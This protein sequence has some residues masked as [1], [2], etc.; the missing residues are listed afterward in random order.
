MAEVQFH[1]FTFEN[2]VKQEFF[3]GHV[4][5]YSS[6]WDVPA[7]L[8]RSDILQS[9]FRGL[10]V[11]IKT[12]R[13]GSPLGLGD[14]VRQIRIDYDFVMIAGFWEQRTATDKFFTQIGAARITRGRWQSLWSPIT[15]TQ[16]YLL[17]S[18]VKDR[19]VHY[20]DTRL[21]AQEIKQRYRFDTAT[22]VVNPK[23]D[24]KKQ[25][26]VQC[27]IPNSS[28]WELVGETPRPTDNPIFWNRP[29]K[30]PVKSSA[31]KFKKDSAPPEF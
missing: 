1:G 29:F 14:A 7:E 26:R 24:S 4:G 5:G 3:A 15:T 19:K 9:E 13:V 6:H 10:P 16:I 28:F 20:V 23:I 18:A 21:A 31:R 17:D 30:N 2:W 25:R 22:I 11:S 27:S 8:N 12:A